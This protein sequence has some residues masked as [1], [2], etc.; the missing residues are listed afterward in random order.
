MRLI[1]NEYYKQRCLHSSYYEKIGNVV[2]SIDAE[3]PFD[4]PENWLWV[5]LSTIAINFDSSRK[6]INSSE[7]KK[8]IAKK[9]KHLLYPYYGSTGQVGFIDDYIFDGKYVLLGEDG[10]P[11]L[12]KFASKAYI[13]NGKVWVNNHVHILKPLIS[14]EYLLCCLNSIDY[15][16][17]VYG[18]TR[19]KLTQENMN[20]IMIPVPPLNEQNKISKAI[21]MLST[22]LRKIER[23]IN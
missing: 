16:N 7:R 4:L 5:R 10:A 17:Y 19:L 8:R 3:V 20:K 21:D 13:V 2:K 15:T 1:R 6:P 9:E 18:T 14:S 23:S 22:H 12:D 11:F